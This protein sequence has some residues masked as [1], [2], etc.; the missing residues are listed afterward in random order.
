MRFAVS[1]FLGLLA[2]DEVHARALTEAGRSVDARAKA[3]FDFNHISDLPLSDPRNNGHANPASKRDQ[4]LPHEYPNPGG[5]AKS[6]SKRDQ[7]LSGSFGGT[8]CKPY[9]HN[10][11][12]GAE[13]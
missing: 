6:A 10:Y 1:V 5:V 7:P 9:P 4:P 2:L 3:D 11:P 8:G 12:T 13:D